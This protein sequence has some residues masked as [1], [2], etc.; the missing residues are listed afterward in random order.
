MLVD[1]WHVGFVDLTGRQGLLGQVEGRTAQVVANWLEQRS[2]AWRDQVR[3]VAIDMCSVFVCALRTALPNATIVVDHFHVIQLANQALTDVRRRVTFTLRARRGR[4]GDGEWDVRNLLTR[5]QENLSAHR[6][7]KMWNTLV[8]LGY[9]ILAAYIA[10]EK[11]RELFALARTG[12]DRHRI[13]QHLYDFYLWCASSD[14]LE[15]QRLAT[16]IERWWPYIEA[17]LHTRITNA[18]SEGVNRV[19]KLT[20]RNTYGFTNTNNQRL[21]VRC[22]TT[23]KARGH[24]KPA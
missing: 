24:L 22:V 2:Q 5:N 15:L 12:P 4:K 6:F 14:L 17:F 7:A 16:T 20:A 8:D 3:Y 19:V 10:K 13:A 21:R 18:G 11:L 1:R 9:R 23:R